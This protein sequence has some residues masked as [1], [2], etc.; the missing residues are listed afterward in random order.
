M[1]AALDTTIAMS[2]GGLDILNDVHDI[3]K[4]PGKTADVL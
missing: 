4:E 1:G 3:F 2:L